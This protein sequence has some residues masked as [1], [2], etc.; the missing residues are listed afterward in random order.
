MNSVRL[1]DSAKTAIHRAQKELRDNEGLYR[2]LVDG[3]K[4]YAIFMLDQAG[5]IV[6]WNTGAEQIKGYRADEILGRHF[7]YLYPREDAESGKP[8]RELACAVKDGSFEEE[9]WRLKKDGSRFW[10]SVV[11]T[12]LRDGSGD[13]RGFAKV[14]R[15]ITKRFEA[16]AAEKKRQALELSA[17]ERSSKHDFLTGL[18]N[19]KLLN[20]RTD[21][22]IALARRHMTKLAI[23]FLDLDG[24][25]NINDTLGH[26]VGDKLLKLVASRLVKCVRSTD[27]VS[28]LGGDEFVALLSEVEH[29]EDAAITATR[30]LEAVAETYSIDEHDLH[31]TTSI[32]VS[33]YPDDSRDTETLIKCADIAMYQ[34]KE[35]GRQHYQ[36]FETTMTDRAVEAQFFR[37]GLR[38]ALE[39]K[40][41]VL[42]YQP[43]LD[44][45]TGTIVGAEALIR[46]NHPT[47]GMISPENFIPFAEACGL[48]IPIGAWVLREACT[49]TRSWADS[50]L[51]ITI[52]V[53]VSAAELKNEYFTDDLFATLGETGLD[54]HSLIMELT[55]TVLVKCAEST[56]ITL[57]SLRQRGVRVSLDDFGTGY[58]SLSYLQKFPVDSLKID[59]AFIRQIAKPTDNKHIVATIIGMARN[60]KLRIVAEGVETL[61]ELSFI[62]AHQCDEAQGYY[63]SPPVQAE[64]FAKLLRTGVKVPFAIAAA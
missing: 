12:A 37:Q 28:R 56:A 2:L 18:P 39:Q 19:R 49:Q 27:T 57:Q 53:N 29:A 6:S 52:A 26:K 38:R 30:M 11:I 62:R 31:V 60:L 42:Y 47:R 35:N 3:I 23:L 48:I 64:E 15:D 10:A 34:A 43:K 45:R 9:G 4:D 58:S 5:N 20:E 22:A 54:P 24:F 13:L 7:S 25:K 16:E 33:I 51:P 61:E 63:F 46:W 44:L 21:H 14:V 59:Q 1:D 41:F 8:Q 50:G 40:E 55:E 32:G 17:A 36:F